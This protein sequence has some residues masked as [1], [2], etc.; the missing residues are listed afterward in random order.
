ML[1]FADYQ[2][3]FKKLAA[4]TRRDLDDADQ[5][6]TCLKEAI[7]ANDGKKKA[8]LGPS[9]GP[10][11]VRLDRASQNKVA[12]YLRKAGLGGNK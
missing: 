8:T 12:T 4:Q 1:F 9:A 2:P 6:D 7:V 11:K 5:A 3:Q 10:K